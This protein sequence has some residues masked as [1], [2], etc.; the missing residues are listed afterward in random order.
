MVGSVSGFCVAIPQ[1]TSSVVV[2][3]SLRRLNLCLI[4]LSQVTT[5]LTYTVSCRH[6]GASSCHTSPNMQS[7]I[8]CCTN[9]QLCVCYW[10]NCVV[11]YTCCGSCVLTHTHTLTTPTH[12][13]PHTPPTPTHSHTQVNPSVSSHHQGLSILITNTSISHS[14]V[15]VPWWIRGLLQYPVQAQ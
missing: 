6:L 14:D 9:Y 1:M 15:G 5:L 13:P 2:P 3:V 7:S 12:P 4:V 8:S 11:Q 10:L